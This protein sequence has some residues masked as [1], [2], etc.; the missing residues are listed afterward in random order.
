MMPPWLWR[1]HACEIV[2]AGPA[3]ISAAGRMGPQAGQSGEG[4]GGCCATII[5]R[6]GTQPRPAHGVTSRPRHV[7]CVER[8]LHAPIGQGRPRKA[9]ATMVDTVL[10]V[11][12]DRAT[13]QMIQDALEMEGYRVLR[14]VGDAAIAIA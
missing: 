5:G 6:A 2:C 12:D 14:A 8:H 3:R 9:L 7:S 4:T 13:A 10:V 1:A 11:E